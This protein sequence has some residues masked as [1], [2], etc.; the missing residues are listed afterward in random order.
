M[1][2]LS[3]KLVGQWAVICE[4]YLGQPMSGEVKCL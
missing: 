2:V 4:E 1:Y 3:C